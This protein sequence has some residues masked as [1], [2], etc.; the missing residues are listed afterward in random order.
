MCNYEDRC[1]YLERQPLRKSEQGLIQQ[2]VDETE[3]SLTSEPRGSKG[4]AP[5]PGY[6]YNQ[7]TLGCTAFHDTVVGS[8]PPAEVVLGGLLDHSFSNTAVA[9]NR[10][11]A[12][13]RGPIG[14]IFLAYKRDIIG[15]FPD[16]NLKRVILGREYSHL[17]E[18]TEAVGAFN[19]ITIQ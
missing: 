7:V 2:A 15:V 16:N 12:L 14:I 8:Y 6:K 10:Q 13:V 9:F 17:R 1:Y 18:V 5:A 4:S 19:T 11:F 3:I